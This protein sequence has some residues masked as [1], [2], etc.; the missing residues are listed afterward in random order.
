VLES[1]LD[2]ARRVLSSKLVEL[3][4]LETERERLLARI[5]EREQ[6]VR[7]LERAHEEA[8]QRAAR[9][10]ELEAK[11]ASLGQL[12]A[13]ARDLEQIARLE[14]E[15]EEALWSPP[16][17]DDLTKIKG[18]GPKYA[19]ALNGL[20]IRRFSEIAA[21]TEDDLA[22]VAKKLGVPATRIVKRGWIESARA[23]AR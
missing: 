11:L 7:Q 16:A 23:L 5:N 19:A 8:R 1:E 17:D 10:H 20:G 2:H 13:R 21:W 9:A 22:R 18:I 15:L 4:S 6:R 14:R 12:E 3:K